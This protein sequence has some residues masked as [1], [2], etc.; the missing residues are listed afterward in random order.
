M[1]NVITPLAVDI[2]NKWLDNRFYHNQSASALSLGFNKIQ[3]LV[4]K[5]Q[6]LGKPKGGF[7]SKLHTDCNIFGNHVKFLIQRD[8]RLII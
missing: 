1:T 5:K 2:D 8:K 3:K 7:S 6:E 4:C